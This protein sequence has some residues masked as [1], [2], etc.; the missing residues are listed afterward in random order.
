MKPK[1]YPYSGKKKQPH[2]KKT[3]KKKQ[4]DDKKSMINHLERATKE[5]KYENLC[6]QTQK[7]DF[8]I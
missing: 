2:E 4:N 7:I 6:K 8:E 1:Q 3:K 5:G